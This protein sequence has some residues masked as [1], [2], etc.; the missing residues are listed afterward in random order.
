MVDIWESVL[1][2]VVRLQ[3]CSGATL[4]FTD[5]NPELYQKLDFMVCQLIIAQFISRT[6]A[7]NWTV[8]K[9]QAGELN[10]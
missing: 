7:K 6:T 5:L 10:S 3:K 8:N 4:Q 2:S 9:Y 1:Y